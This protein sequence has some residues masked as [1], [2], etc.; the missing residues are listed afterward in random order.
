MNVAPDA[1]RRAVREAVVVEHMQSENVQ[2]WDRAVATTD[3]R[4]VG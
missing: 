2:R 1:E 3:G 4:A